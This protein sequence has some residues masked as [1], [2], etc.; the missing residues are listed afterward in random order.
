MPTSVRLYQQS[1]ARQDF[2]NWWPLKWG[3]IGSSLRHSLLSLLCTWLSYAL[4]D[5]SEHC[6]F[7]ALLAE[8]WAAA[9]EPEWPGEDAWKCV[10]VREG[11]CSSGNYT[12]LGIIYCILEVTSTSSV[13]SLPTWVQSLAL[14]LIPARSW[15][16]LGASVPY[17]HTEN[18]HVSHRAL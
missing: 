17:L 13:V 2:C 16:T 6:L 11:L 10:F 12:H 5:Q 18:Q 7:S 15:A 3:I 14:L 8:S 1:F 4:G 9:G